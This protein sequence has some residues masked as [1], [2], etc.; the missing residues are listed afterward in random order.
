M[1]VNVGKSKEM[2]LIVEEGLQC[3]VHVDGICFEHV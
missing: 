3:E 2:V 1:K